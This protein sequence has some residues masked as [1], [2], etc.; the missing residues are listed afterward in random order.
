M[1][2]GLTHKNH[3]PRKG[4]PLMV[5]VLDINGQPLMPTKRYGKVRRLL[6][7][8]KAKVI[9]KCP[10]TI[11]LQ[12]ESTTHTQPVEVGDDTGAVHN[13]ISAVV[14]YPC[15]KEVEVYVAEVLMRTDIVGLLSTRREFRRSRRNRTTRYRAPRFNNRVKS[16]NKGWLEPS[17]EN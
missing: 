10:F 12:Y 3:D 17:V 16:K 8:H 13:G 15:G 7:S 6:K 4:V 14:V 9:H 11:Q 2:P 5:Y 1:V